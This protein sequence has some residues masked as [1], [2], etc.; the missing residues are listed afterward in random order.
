MAD[1]RGVIAV[2]KMGTKVL[3]LD[4][5]TYETQVVID[6]FPRT[7]E[8]AI[9]LDVLMEE[10][11]VLAVVEIV[12]PDEELVRRLS[13]R[14]AVEGRVDDDAAVVRERLSVY[15][16]STRPVIDFYRARHTLITVNGHASAEEVTER[17]TS[18]ALNYCAT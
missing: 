3:F 4:P 9:A 8:Q 10:R 12:V 7:V 6:G 16:R 13:H 11:G 15:H 14:R 17:I 18:A 2:D 1:A 5:S